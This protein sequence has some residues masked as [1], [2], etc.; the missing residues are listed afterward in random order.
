MGVHRITSESARFYAMRERIV[1]SAISLIGEA[2]L[3][4]DELSKEQCE[5][6]GDLA[7]KLLPYA[8]GYAGK[9]MPIIARLFW[10][11]ANVKEKD[12]PL[13]E[14]DKLEKEV[15]DLRKELGL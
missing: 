1:G 2:S 10:K 4:I 13:V 11:L 7:S 8:P 12:F 3:K 5:K 15:E 6:L 9:T 14:M